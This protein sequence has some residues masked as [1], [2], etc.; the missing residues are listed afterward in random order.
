MNAQTNQSTE[1][2][3]DAIKMIVKIPENHK[4]V[5]FVYSLAYH[6]N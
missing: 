5:S 2:V 4:L 3:I 6:F 1:N